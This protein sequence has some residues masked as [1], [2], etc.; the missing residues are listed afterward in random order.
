MAELL[1]I[2]RARQ[3]QRTAPE[4]RRLGSVLV[5]GIEAPRYRVSDGANSYLADT[6]ISETLHIGDRVWIARDGGVALIVGFQGRDTD[7]SSQ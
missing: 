4:E 7:F 5:I 2:L 1:N 6:A 3:R